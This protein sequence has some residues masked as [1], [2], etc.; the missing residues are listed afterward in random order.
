MGKRA[1]T[2]CGTA[3]YVA[4]EVL[5]GNGYD[6]TVDWWSLGCFVYE[7]L[8]GSPP[9]LMSDKVRQEQD[10]LNVTHYYIA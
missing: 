1:K 7:M 5:Q 8:F 10:I 9:F 3:E 6:K 2:I 4:P